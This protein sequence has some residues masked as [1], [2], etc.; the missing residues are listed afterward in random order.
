MST[1]TRDGCYMSSLI[2]TP[3]IDTFALVGPAGASTRCSGYPSPREIDFDLTA[4]SRP[5]ARCSRSV[6]HMTPAAFS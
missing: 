3:L 2:E 4:A 6:N 5:A 1:S